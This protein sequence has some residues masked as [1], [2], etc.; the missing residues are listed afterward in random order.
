[1][2]HVRH[3]PGDSRE[4]RVQGAEILGRVLSYLIWEEIRAFMPRVVTPTPWASAP[5]ASP[6][7]DAATMH[8]SIEGHTDTLRA[9]VPLPL[10]HP[11]SPLFVSGSSDGTLRV[12]DPEARGSGAQAVLRGHTGGIYAL[13]CFHLM[14]ADL[15]GGFY[16]VS[17][18][19][20]NTLRLW[21]PLAGGEA[22][23]VLHG[24]KGTVDALESFV[25]MPR[26]T[27]CV[28]SCSGTEL[29]IWGIAAPPSGSA[30]AD[31]ISTLLVISVAGRVR[32]LSSFSV[33]LASGLK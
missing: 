10:E 14:S 19:F 33:G 29:R 31:S 32:G 9:L 27:Q 6:A 4:A 2:F 3:T 24:H 26:A 16:V 20:D 17:G 15:S 1:M 12:W 25:L 5:A 28:A 23:A 22:L 7:A 30:W 11:R 21:D 18:A 13:T 8:D